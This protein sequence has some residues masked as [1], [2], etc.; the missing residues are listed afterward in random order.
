MAAALSFVEPGALLAIRDRV[1][2]FGGRVELD[3]AGGAPELRGRI[4]LTRPRC[5]GGRRVMFRVVL[6]EDDFLLREGVRAM[7]NRS[8]SIEVVGTCGDLPEALTATDALLPA[9]EREVLAGIAEGR[10]NASIAAELFVTQH[11]VE[12]H[13][14]AIFTKL[15]L[16]GDRTNHPRVR[17]TLMYLAEGRR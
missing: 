13:I 16:S 5:R 8:G 6:A 3:T 17:A 10:N 11:S 15:G 1:E 12:K 9:R 14:N 7:L 4:P 2:A